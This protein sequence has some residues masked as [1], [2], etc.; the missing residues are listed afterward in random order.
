MLYTVCM[1]WYVCIDKPY[2]Y[3]ANSFFS[4]NFTGGTSRREDCFSG[5]PVL[6]LLLCQVCS[7]RVAATLQRCGGHESGRWL[8]S[9]RKLWQRLGGG[10]GWFMLVLGPWWLITLL[11]KSRGRVGRASDL[12][13][14][15]NSLEVWTGFWNDFREALNSHDQAGLY[16]LRYIDKMS[17]I[18]YLITAA[19][20]DFIC[21]LR[22][23]D[24]QNPACFGM[25]SSSSRFSFWWVDSYEVLGWS[26]AQEQRMGPCICGIRRV[27][28][29]PTIP[30]PTMVCGMFDRF[31]TCFLFLAVAPINPSARILVVHSF[32]TEVPTIGT[33]PSL[34]SCVFHR[35]WSVSSLPNFICPTFRGWNARVSLQ[36]F[37]T[38][39][40][41]WSYSISYTLP[42]S[43][44]HFTVS[45]FYETMAVEAVNKKVGWNKIIKM[46]S[47]FLTWVYKRNITKR[48]SRRASFE[49]VSLFSFLLSE[50]FAVSVIKS[51]S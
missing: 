43:P 3:K 47:H 36:E 51:S 5:S 12:E 23:P 27:T 44:K 25:V 46:I 41:R 29:R 21:S 38:E 9:D 6:S 40:L 19:Q 49:R 34:G 17:F 11:L 7:C 32:C 39:L 30:D 16:S 10:F 18:G 33:W 42:G 28:G 45:D 4:K 1:Y 48:N 35:V 37:G 31:D 20:E 14:R 2:I 13:Y 8:D 24:W 26:S 15:T 22:W 50:V